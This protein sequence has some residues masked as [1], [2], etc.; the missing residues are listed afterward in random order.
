[1]SS[2]PRFQVLPCGSGS[3]GLYDNHN[4][5]WVRAYTGPRSRDSAEQVRKERAEPR[6][7]A[8][9]TTGRSR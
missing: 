6:E 4:R 2:E 8:T 3:W 5:Q 1:V 9:R 7:R